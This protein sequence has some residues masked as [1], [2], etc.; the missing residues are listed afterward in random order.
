M[1]THDMYNDFLN[2]QDYVT[3]HHHFS[4]ISSLESLD[5]LATVVLELFSGVVNKTVP[6]PYYPD[7]PYGKDQLQVCTM[8]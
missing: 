3:T 1:S 8:T 7:H 4:L 5:D 2:M 6:P